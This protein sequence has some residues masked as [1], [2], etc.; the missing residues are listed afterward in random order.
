M[1]D[2]EEITKCEECMSRNISYDEFR[3]ETF[4]EDCG[5]VI[6]EEEIEKT[7]SGRE[8][9][10][11]PN[12]PMTHSVNKEGYTLGSIVGH[13]NADGSLDKS[14]VGRTLR[15]WQKRAA[16]TSQE[17]NTI[18]GIVQVNMLMAEFGV[19]ET[20][21]AQAVW[22]YKRLQKYDIM[23][24]SSL[25]VRA[26]AICYYTFKDNGI[27]RTIDEVCSKNSAHPRQVAK[28]ARKIAAYFRKPWVL[29]QRNITQEVEKYCS[30][31][32][33]HRTYTT[34][35]IQLSE[36]LHQMAQERYITTNAGYLAACLYLT[37]RLLKTTSIRTQRDI[38][39]VC[40]IT[41]VTLRNNLLV[42]LKMVNMERGDIETTSFEDFMTGARA[43][44]K[45]E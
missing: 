20:L 8:R 12:S 24:G 4:C 15:K 43:W 13:R 18:K 10:G 36:L 25:E 3:G 7:S 6:E 44:Q 34:A 26:A 41:E 28:L 33:V 23:R 40:N 32:G 42:M 17:K 21:L 39:D 9:T 29:S 11:D 31:L 22:N 19:K 14:P 1:V 27:S 45:D 5:L 35:A 16:Q 30:M 2:V 37:G 38:S